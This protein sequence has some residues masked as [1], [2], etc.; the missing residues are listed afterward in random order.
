MNRCQEDD[1]IFGLYKASNW[2]MYTALRDD[3]SS[4]Y[5]EWAYQAIK[6]Y[7][8]SGRAYLEWEQ[9]LAKADP[10]KLLLACWRYAV[11]HDGS[12]DSLLK[13]ATAY[14]KHYCGL[15]I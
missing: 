11:K 13:A 5:T 2:L 14:L 8:R 1:I 9:A 3:P 7:I 10:E 12:D 4:A 15:K 6:R